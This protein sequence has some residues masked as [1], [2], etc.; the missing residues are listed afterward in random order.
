MQMSKLTLAVIGALLATSAQAGSYVLQ[1]NKWGA[2][3]EAAVA[4]AGGRVVYASA[5]AG[6]A[7]VESDNANFASAMK[8]SRTVTDVDVDVVLDFEKPVVSEPVDNQKA[9]E[10][11]LQGVVDGVVLLETAKGKIH[12]L[13]LDLIKR[14]RLEVEF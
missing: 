11:H 2:A 13:P 8:A 10:G 3:Q 12:R 9:F 14:G 4:A 5:R 6:I 7:V 1:A